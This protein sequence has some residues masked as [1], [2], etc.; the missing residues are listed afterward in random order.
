ME[1]GG[2]PGQ[3]L[4]TAARVSHHSPDQPGRDRTVEEPPTGWGPSVVSAMAVR[5]RPGGV[6]SLV[7]R[8][9]LT[10]MID[11]LRSAEADAVLPRCPRR[12]A[13]S[14]APTVATVRCSGALLPPGR[15]RPVSASASS[16]CLLLD[17]HFGRLVDGSRSG[18]SHCGSIAAAAN[19][20]PAGRMPLVTRR[21]SERTTAAALDSPAAA[22]GTSVNSTAT[23]VPSSPPRPA[24]AGAVGD[25]AGRSASFRPGR[26]HGYRHL[27]CSST[28]STTS[29]A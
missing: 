20:T 19:T 21:P 24:C 7:L 22:T 9:L 4:S 15:W 2:V 8:S 26:A 11:T 17:G 14:T 10:T 29:P 18:P 13:V 3:V 12:H 16:P 1:L 27:P 5:G 6:A 28:G 25:R 23:V